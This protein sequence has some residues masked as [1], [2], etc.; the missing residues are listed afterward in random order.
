[1]T[2]LLGG[3]RKSWCIIIINRIII[4]YKSLNVY[5]VVVH[6]I[7]ERIETHLVKW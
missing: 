3:G 6:R 5:T 7:G 2:T 1:M 4:R